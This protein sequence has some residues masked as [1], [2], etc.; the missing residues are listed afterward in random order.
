MLTTIDMLKG[1][2]IGNSVAEFDKGLSHYFLKTQIFFDI[3]SDKYDIV[4]GDKGSGK[5]AIYRALR[6]PNQTSFDEHRLSIIPGFNESGAPVFRRLTD[7]TAK[8]EADFARLWKIYIFAVVANF[9]CD[10]N[11]DDGSPELK[12]VH[13]I[14]QLN[15]LREKSAPIPSIWDRV[16]ALIAKAEFQFESKGGTVKFEFSP[17]KAS[18]ELEDHITS[19]LQL[20]DEYLSKANKRAWI[21]FDRLD[22]SFASA[23]EV[24]IPALRALCRTYLD[25]QT[26][27][28][29]KIKLFFR[30]DLFRKI[31]KGG[32]VNLTHLEAKSV[33][34]EW[35][36]DDLHALLCARIRQNEYLMTAMGV[37]KRTS[38]AT[39]FRGF[40]PE[41]VD[42]GDKRPTTWNWIL[43][44]IEDGNGVRA[45]RNLIDLTNLAREAQ[46][47]KEQRSVKVQ[48]KKHFLFDPDSLKLALQRLSERR[49][50]DTIMA[51]MGDVAT[52]IEKL[53]GGKAEHTSK[54]LSD[55]FKKKGAELEAIIMSL[56]EA[57][58]LAEIGESYKVPMLY[59]SGLSITQG[60]AFD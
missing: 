25:L 39:L 3:A 43:T 46:L 10:A 34:I 18:F 44:R 1:L 23:P 9:L 7:G 38:N 29:I 53:R 54:S 45:P 27:Q 28:R 52:F 58:L 56:K 36:P 50:T 47:A 12:S 20:I 14:L 11:P 35:T 24:E 37:D 49:V 51:E 30:Q 21:L 17:G 31:A 16:R 60:K 5:S 22:E 42:A 15:E 6:E 8:S 26:L 33:N 40:F 4:K 13:G 41:Q 19:A 55:T 48:R 57:G 32:F 2:D 59:R